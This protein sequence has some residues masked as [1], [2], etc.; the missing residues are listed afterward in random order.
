M[1]DPGAVRQ[2]TSKWNFFIHTYLWRKKMYVLNGK[3]NFLRFI[4]HTLKAVPEILRP[5]DHDGQALFCVE[6]RPGHPWKYFVL[7]HVGPEVFLQRVHHG[8]CNN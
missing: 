2:F 4:S 6:R 3:L 5:Q 1:V 7:V 8:R